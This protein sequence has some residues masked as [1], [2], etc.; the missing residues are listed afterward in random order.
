LGIGAIQY[1]YSI[2]VYNSMQVDFGYL[3]GWNTEDDRNLWNALITSICAL[4]SAIGSLIAGPPADRY[5]KLKCIHVTNV[6]VIIGSILACIR[7]E[8]VILFGRFVF[9][10][11]TGAFSVFVPSFIN[12][13]SPN[14]MK[15]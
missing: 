6:I 15:G 2:G 3:F 4:G 5:G 11:A 9:G 10:F 1:G 12:E 8:Y 7:N 13:L 14:E